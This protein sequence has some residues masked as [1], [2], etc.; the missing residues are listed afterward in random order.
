MNTWRTLAAAALLAGC[1]GTIQ[2]PPTGTPAGEGTGGTG[3]P[4]TSAGTGNQGTGNQGSGGTSGTTSTT[5]PDGSTTTINPDG[6]TTT[7][8]PDGTTSTTDPATDPYACVPGIPGTTQLPRLTKVQ[9]DNTIRDLV[10]LT[11]LAGVTPS[12]TL[13]PDGVG[14]VDQRSWDAYQAT[15]DALAAAVMVSPAAR[16]KAIGCTTADDACAASFIANFGKRAF[17]RPLTAAETTK[18]TALYTNRAT[19]TET[20]TFDEIAQVI[21]RAFLR[22]PSFLTR[23]ETTEVPSGANYALSGYEVASRLSYLLWASMPD[24]ALLAAADAGSLDTPAGILTEAKR[25]LNDPEGKARGMVTAFHQAYAKMG[26]GT[27]WAD[28]QRDPAFYGDFTTD[29]MTAA[30]LETERL[31]DEVVFTKG[32]TFQ[33]LFTTTS[34]YVNASLAPIYGLNPADFGTELEPATLDA[35]VRPGIFTRAGFLTAYSLFDRSSPILRG[36]FLQKQ[37]LCTEIGSP[38]PDAAATP[39]PSDPGL[40]TNRQKTDAQTAGAACV[41]CHHPLVNPTGFPLEAFDAIGK[42]QTVEHDTG[43]SIDT[44]A[45]VPISQDQVVKVEVDGPAELMQ[46]IANSVEAQ[47]CYARRWVEYAYERPLNKQDACVVRDM[48]TKLT[49]GGYKVLDLIADLTQ[50]ESFRARAVEVTP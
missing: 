26:A 11:E 47:R 17:R 33:E 37:I 36:A 31:F 29:T 2:G 22:S 41:G 21:I 27:R 6:T 10:G 15:A 40:V 3:K 20:G 45:L 28:V 44:Q 42:F 4:G 49:L 48:A 32:G 24:D 46:A 12:S 8:S 1:N 34:A 39:V 13:A 25:M 23:A 30:S 5:N 19:L 50:S 35:A 43:A 18:Y 9:Y 38:P 16:S 14:S 7:T